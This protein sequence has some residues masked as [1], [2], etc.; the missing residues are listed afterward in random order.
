MAAKYYTTVR[1]LEILS[2][3]SISK[4]EIYLRC[5]ITNWLITTIYI[6]SSDSQD[7][8]VATSDDDTY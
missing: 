3:N 7:I 2:M 6:S 5:Q 4:I 1:Y 8:H